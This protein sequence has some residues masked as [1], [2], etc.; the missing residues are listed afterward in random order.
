MRNSRCGN[1][2]TANVGPGD[3]VAKVNKKRNLV[4]AY[5]GAD[6]FGRQTDEG[7]TELRFAWL[8]P[9]GGIVLFRKDTEIMTNETTLTRAGASST[10]VSGGANRNGGYTN[11]SGTAT[12][13]APSDYHAVIPAGSLEIDVPKGT[14]AIPF[15]GHTVR[16]LNATPVSLSYKLD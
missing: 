9:D 12:T 16:F 7:F 3:I 14:D 15:E 11:F 1:H 6:I 5:G 8:K 13:F 2:L 4:N 10:F